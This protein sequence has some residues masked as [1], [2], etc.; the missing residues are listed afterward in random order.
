M[1][2]T[3]ARTAAKNLIDFLKSEEGTHIRGFLQGRIN[4]IEHY[5]KEE[6]K[7]ILILQQLR[8]LL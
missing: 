5:T 1:T 4:N 7:L 6:V 8:K 2:V 3:K